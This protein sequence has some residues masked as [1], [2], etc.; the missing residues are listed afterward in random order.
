MKHPARQAGEHE[1]FGAWLIEL[2]ARHL[3]DLRFA[4]VTRALRALSVDYVQKRGAIAG[5]T[6]LAGA[7]KRAAFALFYA[8][9]HFLIVREILRALG[10]DISSVGAG[11]AGDARPAWA[12]RTLVDLGCGTGAA[13]AA[14]AAACGSPR[15]VVGVDRHPWAIDEAART[16]RHFGLRAR[17]RRADLARVAVPKGP[18][19]WIAAFALNELPGDERDAL[20][21]RLVERGDPALVVEPLA[22][23]AAPWWPRWAVRIAS[24]GGR[25]DEWRFRVP[26][27]A[28][29]QKLDRAA[30]LDHRELT[31]RSLFIP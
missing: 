16:Y 2:E 4:D 24:A 29:V 31:A 20:L 22:R 10:S 18:A 12:D 1:Q 23:S 11:G 5:G 27:P 17:T 30:G 6:A 8:P 9:L 13:G 21:A 14:W 15:E 7:G 28:I 26:L 3:A 25:A 19:A